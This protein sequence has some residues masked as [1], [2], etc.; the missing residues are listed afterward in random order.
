MRR[1]A[2]IVIVLAMLVTQVTAGQNSAAS[3]RAATNEALFEA[4]RAGDTAGIAA[5][6]DRGADVNAKARYDVTPLIFAAG[7][8]KLEAVRLLVARG[9]DVNSQDSFY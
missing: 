4:A 6:L 1:L 7:G 3:N 9:A 8:G 2:H 5:A